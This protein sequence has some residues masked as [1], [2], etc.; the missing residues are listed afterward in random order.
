[1]N[2]KKVVSNNHLR[3]NRSR[4][5]ENFETRNLGWVTKILAKASCRTFDS[6]S[7]FG[8]DA[9]VNGLLSRYK[10]VFKKPLEVSY[11]D[12]GAWKPIQDSNTFFLYKSGRKGTA[13]EPNP[14][15]VHQWKAT[16][17][18]DH[19]INVGCSTNPVEKMNFFHKLASSNTLNSDFA[20]SIESTQGYKVEATI[21]VPCL[22]LQEIVYVHTE[23]FELPYILDIDVEGMDF[24][25]IQTFDFRFNRPIVVIIE[26]APG[27]GSTLSESLIHKFLTGK[28][29]GMFG[30]TTI[31]SIYIDLNH[32][33][34]SVA[35]RIL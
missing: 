18:L 31:S 9:L 7:A 35:A 1:M 11:L 20:A 4:F 33:L 32:D 3:S 2:K 29:Y 21:D 19:L 23:R 15:L 30:R 28:S 22:T 25:V 6:Y 34:A 16:R 14:N 5:L 8:E 13:V 10:F 24:E 26:D 12:I 27:N 17:P